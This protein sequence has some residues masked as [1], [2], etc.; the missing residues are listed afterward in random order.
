M[1]SLAHSGAQRIALAEYFTFAWSSTGRIALIACLLVCSLAGC[2]HA[3]RGGP[4]STMSLASS[5]TDTSALT[6]AAK[7]LLAAADTTR[8]ND[9]VRRRLMLID[10][11]Y[12]DY[13][14]R[15]R[16]DKTT[17]DL[18]T[19]LAGLAL[20][21][22]GTMAESVAAKTNY[23][24]AGT[25]L[26]GG[27]AVVDQT[28]YYEQTVLALVAAMDANRAE[29]RL[30]IMTALANPLDQYSSADAYADLIAYERA[31]TLLGA[32]GYIQ[33][34]S[35]AS[36]TSADDQIQQIAALTPAQ[37]AD[38]TCSTRSLFKNNAKR[39]ASNLVTAATAL[40]IAIDDK[41]KGDA[42]KIAAKLHLFNQ[43]ADAATVENVYAALKK[44]NVILD[45]CPPP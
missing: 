7:E 29:H 40:G 13:V 43:N 19:G 37:R 18:A 11:A 25:L 6:T 9:I 39:S 42:D 34:T 27:A 38:K 33:V 4:D 12:A 3:L 35:K 16:H 24:A 22:A 41:D 10:Q 20:G 14:V 2:T 28:L 1:T 17:M 8:R 23:A 31:G 5:S 26:V 44:A 30:T 36:Q 15:L 45:G 21:V 32:I